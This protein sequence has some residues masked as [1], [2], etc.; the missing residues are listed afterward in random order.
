MYLEQ[1]KNYDLCVPE[2]VTLDRYEGR[3]GYMKKILIICEL[4]FPSSAI[5]AV[6]PSKIAKYL[7]KDGY[8]V[9]VF[10]RNTVDEEKIYGNVWGYS[11]AYKEESPSI[12][13][14]SSSQVKSR[15][16]LYKKLYSHKAALEDIAKG[17][18][19]L[20]EFKSFLGE[21]GGKYDAVFSTFGPVG[22]LMCG[23]YYK[24]HYPDVRWIC[25]FRDPPIVDFIPVFKKVYLKILENKA[26]KAADEIVAV[27]DGYLERICNGK[28]LEKKHMIPNGYDTDD[29]YIPEK[30]AASDCLRFTY[31]GGLYDGKRDLSYLFAAVKELSD[32]G[33]VDL[34][35]IV[36]NYAGT[37]FS[38]LQNQAKKYGLEGILDNHGLQAREDCLKLQFESN[39]LILANWNTKKEY[40]VFP[41]KLLEYMLIG[42]PIVGITLGDIANSEADSV[43]KSGNLGFSFEEARKREDL[44]LLK[45][46]IKNQYD[47]AISGKGV[48]FAPVISVVDRYNCKNTVKRIKELIEK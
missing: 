19:M 7:V 41:G 36:F 23:L 39:I 16:A 5:G 8:E 14:K 12:V 17:N 9:D 2:S 29:I 6:R 37:N 32:D 24:K 31:V 25:D 22:S 34:Q 21:N 42:K 38:V 11:R 18:A 40:G 1:T 4:F 33:E 20:R 3:E 13:Q 30:G 26:C 10:T 27:S 43:I 48:E 45:E 47:N 46:Y 28:Y 15:G 35:K 44:P